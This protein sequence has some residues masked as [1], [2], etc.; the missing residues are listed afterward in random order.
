MPTLDRL[1][2]L[3][4]PTLQRLSLR[5]EGSVQGVGFRPWCVQQAMALGLTGWVRND[6]RGL[7]LQVQG[8]PEAVDRLRHRLREQPPPLARLDRITEA[9]LTSN[10]AEREFTI[11]ASAD[12][13]GQALDTGLP[14][15]TAPCAACLDELFDPTDRRHRHPFINCTHCGPRLTVTQRLPYDRPQTSMAGFPMCPACAAEYQ[16]PL[17]RRYH[18]QPTACPQC[19]PR[20]A[21]WAPDGTPLQASDPIQVAALRLAAGEVL[22]VKGVGGY[23][24]VADVRRPDALQ[25][26]RA[27]KR[28]AR[29]PFALLVPN[30]ASARRWVDV[31]APSEA[32]LHSPA[33]PVLL[34]PTRP[35]VSEAHPLIAPGLNDWGL[36]LPSTPLHWLL[37]HEMLGRPSGTDWRETAH[38]ILLVMTSANPSG[39]PLVVDE[40][41]AVE[42][43]AGLCDA[44]LVHDRPI[45]GR[46]DDSVRRP[47]PRHLD[48]NGKSLQ[49]S[50][51][52][53]G[54]GSKDRI[55][56]VDTPESPLHA[57]VPWHAPFVRRA[58]GHVP[59]PIELPGVPVDAPSVLAVGG[60]LKTTVC[61]T[62]GHQAFLSPHLGDMGSAASRAALVEA[63]DR[64]Q[65]F[66][67]VQPV[68][69]AHDCHPD[70]F[71]TLHAAERARNWGVPLVPV[72]H[73]HAHAAAVL[74][75][76]GVPAPQAALALVLDGV[77]LGDDDTPWG[78]ELLRV[79]HG[80]SRRLAHLPPLA[81][82]GGDRAAGEPWRLGAA[83]LHA[84]G[85]GHEI[86]QRLSAHPAARNVAQML[87]RGLNAPLTSSAGRLF[88]AAAHLLAGVDV[89]HHEGEGAMVLEA[90][91]DRHSG[92]AT[93]WT[94]AWRVNEA[95]VLHWPGLWH[96]LADAP[97]GAE[98][99]AR[100]HT[101]LS[102]SLVDWTVAHAGRENLDTVALGGGCLINRRL[103]HGLVAG[104]TRAGLRVLEARQAPP[105]D[106]GLSLGQAAVALQHLQRG[107]IDPQ[108]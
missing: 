107:R 40:A 58:R 6:A 102:A 45:V 3:A 38:D 69:V 85:R 59:D 25:R 80:T 92:P 35:G 34:L 20:V 55:G 16:N 65:Q 105:G 41:E 11:L 83:V 19:G 94:G 23:H 10:P 93:P 62:R 56:C 97:R 76:H 15:D 8:P 46:V 84:L 37:L 57:D 70:F 12:L 28:R 5:V 1:N 91:A 81:L 96:A 24:L 74:V 36:M 42:R 9:D 14:P 27:A 82:P 49:S 108:G 54:V 67:G 51:S 50:E 71:T 47:Q 98:S 63:I 101:T 2:P 22:A 52:D 32:L 61:L 33:R 18:A 106:G 95:G 44:L 48:P 72:Q 29:K 53:R 103:R 77:G 100:F 31:D 13:G 88:D 64:L 7:D 90:L 104:L 39:E 89:N 78:G 26:L 86:P 21:L 73:H 30:V 66:L 43:L 79:Q 99:A 17:D 75:E 68:A 87:E 4:A 60:Y